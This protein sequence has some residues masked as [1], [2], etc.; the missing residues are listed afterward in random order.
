MKKLQILKE[1]KRFN[2]SPRDSR[3]RLPICIDRQRFPPLDDLDESFYSDF[4]EASPDSTLRSA[5]GL[6]F[7]D[8]SSATPSAIG[9]S[10]AFCW[11]QLLLVGVLASPPAV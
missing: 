5:F 1:K 4:S 7:A 11:I 6:C 2:V 8:F 9:T 3:F 10:V